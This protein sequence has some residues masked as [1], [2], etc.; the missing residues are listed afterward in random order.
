ML[1]GVVVYLE[2]YGDVDLKGF[3]FVNGEFLVWEEL[4]DKFCL[5]NILI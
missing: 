4:S 2:M 3:F 1:E 5:I